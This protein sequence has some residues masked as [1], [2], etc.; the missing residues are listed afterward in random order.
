MKKLA[1][2][3]VSARFRRPGWIVADH[4][5]AVAPPSP[6]TLTAEVAEEAK[7]LSGEVAEVANSLAISAATAKGMDNI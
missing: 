4:G 6:L 2:A 5:Y 3:L 1:L 7:T